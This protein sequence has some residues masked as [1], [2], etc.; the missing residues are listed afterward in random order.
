MKEAGAAFERKREEMR[1][2]QQKVL[3]VEQLLAALQV[4]SEEE[5][6]GQVRGTVGSENAEKIQPEVVDRMLA[7]VVLRDH[8][9]YLVVK[10]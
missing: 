2:G 3:L 10:A 6:L 7:E 4:K 1:K 8:W 5:V 9:I